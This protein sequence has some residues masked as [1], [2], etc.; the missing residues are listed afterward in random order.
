MMAYK[1]KVVKNP[2]LPKDTKLY[3]A[4]TCTYE[5]YACKSK[6]K[7]VKYVEDCDYEGDDYNLC[8]DALRL[9]GLYGYKAGVAGVYELTYTGKKLTKTAC[10]CCG[11]AEYK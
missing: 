8:A 6:A 2:P 11:G 7:A 3:V 10:K 5:G 4:M 1:K 9:L